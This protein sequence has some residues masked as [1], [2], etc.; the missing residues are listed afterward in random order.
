MTTPDRSTSA[1]GAILD[2][3]A[4]A[5]GAALPLYAAV[6]DW[7]RLSTYTPGP[8]ASEAEFYT[9]MGCVVLAIIVAKMLRRIPIVRH[10]VP[11]AVGMALSLVATSILSVAIYYAGGQ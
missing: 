2:L 7:Q 8:P 4:A 5:A 9:V 6:A 3:L 11:F 10:V 1:L